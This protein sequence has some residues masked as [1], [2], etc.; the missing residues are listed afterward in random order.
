[1]RLRFIILP[2]MFFLL[3]SNVC[4]Q[5]DSTEVGPKITFDETE[6]DF[7]EIEAGATAEHVF[8]FRN[9]GTDT[10]RISQVYSG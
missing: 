3:L 7:G 8:A 5:T 4:A 6:F 1:M 10:L 2:V 9:T